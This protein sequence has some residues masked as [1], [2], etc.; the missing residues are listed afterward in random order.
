MLTHELDG[1]AKVFLE[2]NAQALTLLVEVCSRLIGLCFGRLQESGPHHFLRDRNRAN[3]SS[4]GLASIMPAL[5]AAYRRSASP[6]QSWSFS[7][8]DRPSRLSRSSLANS[9]RAA[10]G[11]S[12]ASTTISFKSLLMRLRSLSSDSSRFHDN[13]IARGEDDRA[14]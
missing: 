6:A 4:A 9:A 11:S 13:H 10:S 12:R 2:S 8:C 5:Y 7:S 3:T 14:A 1:V